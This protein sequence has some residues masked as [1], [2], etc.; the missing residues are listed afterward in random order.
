[1]T[2]ATNADY[3]LDSGQNVSLFMDVELTDE[4]KEKQKSKK[5]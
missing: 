2:Y 4:E 5:N 3:L 1:M